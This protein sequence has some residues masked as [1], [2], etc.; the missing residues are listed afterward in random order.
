MDEKT[1]ELR[2]I[3][4]DV[5]DEET[6]TESQ[7]Q[8]RGSLAE[9][10]DVETEIATTIAEMRDRYEFHT[11][12]DDTALVEL[13]MGFYDGQTDAEIGRALD[14]S[15]GTVIRARMD[16]HLVRDRERQAPFDTEAA[17]TRREMGDSVADIADE[18]DVSESTL[19]RYLRVRDAEI[20]SR[21]ANQRFRDTFD[22]VL[23]D[24]DLAS[25]MTQ[26]VHEDGLDDATEGLETNVSF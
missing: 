4:L 15:R 3:F 11:G 8:S 19:R 22:T 18:F 17:A 23:A 9:R 2:D 26:A 7:E 20:R 21:Q 6:V 25:R 14:C 12:L 16:L 5:A 10:D 13:V 24:A 1:E